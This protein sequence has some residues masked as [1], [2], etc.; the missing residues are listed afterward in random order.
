MEAPKKMDI[1]KQYWLVILLGVLTAFDPLT[2]DMYLPA[3]LLIEQDL[4]TNIS[5]VELSVTLFFIGMA[6]GQLVYG[7]L[8]DKYGRKK[9]LIGGMILYFGATIGCALANH[10]GI[11]LFFRLLQ[12]F[13]GCASM[14]ISRAIIRDLFEKKEV[15]MFLSNLALVM[16]IAPILAPSIGAFISQFFGWRAIFYFLASANLLCIFISMIYLPETNIKKNKN[17]NLKQVISSYLSFFSERSFIGYLI[18]DMAVRAGMFAYIAGSPFVFISLF[19][20]TP[21]EYGIVFGINGLGLLLAAQIN[22]RLLNRYSP[23][24]ISAAAIKVAFIASCILFFFSSLFT[25]LIFILVPLF[26]FIACLNFISPNTIA[27][28][29]NQQSHQAGTASAFYGCFQW[30]MACIA[31]LMVSIF[32][33]G[34]AIPMAATIFVCGIF[35][36]LG[37]QILIQIKKLQPKN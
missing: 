31:S 37:F 29:L 7:P 21:S 8:S 28:A 17:L 12:A 23:E 9:P 25:I 30:S 1:N 34:S 16:G 18:P 10:I 24:E 13:G 36:L 2:I 4:K 6:T 11:F 15:A 20:L 33:D 26:I 22:R 3:F 27:I 35:S 19:K 32:H 14:V 5:L